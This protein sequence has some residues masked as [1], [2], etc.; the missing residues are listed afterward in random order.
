MVLEKDG[1]RIELDRDQVY[2]DDPGQ[3]TPAMLYGP[4]DKSATY[5]C[6][7]DTGEIGN[8]DGL[9]Y[10]IPARIMR[11]LEAQEE[12]VDQFLY[13]EAEERA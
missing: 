11:W 3:G 5:F 1:W 13:S 9:Y 10:D 8:S 2:P 12:Q 7:C 6:A 4:G